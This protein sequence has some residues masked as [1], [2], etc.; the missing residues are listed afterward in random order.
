DIYLDLWEGCAA[1]PDV[2]LNGMRQVDGCFCRAN[3]LY[4]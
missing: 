2:S 4:N 1:Y 3:L